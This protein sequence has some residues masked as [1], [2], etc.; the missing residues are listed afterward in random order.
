MKSC[1]KRK[2]HWRKRCQFAVRGT[3]LAS[4]G[5]VL[6]APKAAEAWHS[7]ADITTITFRFPQIRHLI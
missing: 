6:Q 4:Q 2:Q 7:R 3:L 1:Y 5:Q